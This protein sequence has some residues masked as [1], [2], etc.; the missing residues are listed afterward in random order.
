VRPEEETSSETAA[1][2][3]YETINKKVRERPSQIANIY[4]KHRHNLTRRGIAQGSKVKTQL[5][6]SWWWDPQK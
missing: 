5:K 6:K 3:T 2:H 1:V 4:L